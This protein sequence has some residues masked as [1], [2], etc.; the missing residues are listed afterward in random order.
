MKKSKFDL[1][2]EDIMNNFSDKEVFGTDIHN[3]ILKVYKYNSN[4]F[5]DLIYEI[6]NFKFLEP[7]KEKL[8]EIEDLIFDDD[9]Y[10]DEIQETCKIVVFDKETN[11]A[12]F[13]VITL[14]GTDSNDIIDMISYKENPR[15]IFQGV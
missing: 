11:K 13:E 10:A 14:L 1:L 7:S 8:N 4:G 6:D 12:L 2:F 3:S 9:S 15:G 5:S